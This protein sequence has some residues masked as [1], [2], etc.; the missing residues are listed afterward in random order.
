MKSDIIIFLYYEHGSHYEFLKR[1]ALLF[2]I[3]KNM[4]D[5]SLRDIAEKVSIPKSSVHR[6]INSCKNRVE[7]IGH[8]FF[9]TQLGIEWLCRLIFG[10]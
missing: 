9:E 10:I 7:K 2:K 8:D 3:G 1:A 6:Q 5:K 4:D